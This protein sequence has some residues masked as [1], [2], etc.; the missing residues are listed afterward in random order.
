MSRLTSLSLEES[1][2]QSQAAVLR[3]L[4]QRKTD[5]S[6]KIIA[7]AGFPRIYLQIWQA[8]SV[9]NDIGISAKL[10][11]ERIHLSR[12]S[13]L[14]Y[15]KKSVAIDCLSC[16]QIASTKT[17]IKPTYLFRLSNWLFLE[18]DLIELAIQ[19]QTQEN[20]TTANSTENQQFTPKN[21]SETN[22][23]NG[24][25]HNSY[26]LKLARLQEDIKK[27][28]PNEQRALKLFAKKS[29][30]TSSNAA[31]EL[32]CSQTTAH[33]PLKK[34]YELGILNRRTE[35]SDK[36]GRSGYVY[37]LNDPLTPGLIHVVFNQS[38]QEPIL[39]SELD[40]K[41]ITVSNGSVNHENLKDSK[42]DSMTKE[43]FNH[44]S[45]AQTSDAKVITEKLEQAADKLDELMSLVDQVNQVEEEL[46]KIMG[47]KAEK[48]ITRIKSRIS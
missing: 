38:Q 5:K 10:V 7:L 40:L 31:Q 35:V 36:A 17:G 47:T 39:K 37:F 48:L 4:F 11:G 44:Q 18:K 19:Y 32:N 27:L 25:D 13:A 26:V 2:L 46:R 20:Y 8:A 21:L 43:S 42:S 14:E 24:K 16:E 28:A 23:I 6:A 12:W 41:D 30:T 22:S 34:L 29:E 3:D 15:C 45:V 33:K 1:V 9:E